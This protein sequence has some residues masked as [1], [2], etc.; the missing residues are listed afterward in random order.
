[1]TVFAPRSQTWVRTV[2]SRRTWRLGQVAAVVDFGEADVAPGRLGA[3]GKPLPEP[4]GKGLQVA[5]A[6]DDLRR[7]VK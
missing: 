4:P 7:P 6:E 1:M 3:Q 2:P 5:D